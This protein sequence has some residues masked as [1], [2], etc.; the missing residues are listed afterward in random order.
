MIDTDD[1]LYRVDRNFLGPTGHTLPFRIRY[2]AL[3]IGAA[4]FAAILVLEIVVLHLD[5]AF[6]VV[7]LALAVAIVATSRITRYVD[8]DRPLRSVIRAAYNDLTAPRGA[9]SMPTVALVM[10]EE[11]LRDRNRDTAR[12]RR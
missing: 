10:P 11:A 4:I 7:A 6:T 8:A 9:T 2:T 1:L 3:G 12:S 5:F